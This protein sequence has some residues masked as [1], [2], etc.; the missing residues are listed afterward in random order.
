MRLFDGEKLKG[1]KLYLSYERRRIVSWP[2]IEVEM[3]NMGYPVSLPTLKNLARGA[4]RNPKAETWVSLVDYWAAVLPK[5]C[6]RDGIPIT[7]DYFRV[8]ATMVTRR[9]Q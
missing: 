1:L 4:Q 9:A 2:E 5:G 6:D 3:A 8:Q 7:M